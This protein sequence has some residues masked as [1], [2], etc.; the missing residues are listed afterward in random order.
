MKNYLL[1]FLSLISLTVFSQSL[2][3]E[4]HE[5]YFSP[6]GELCNADLDITNLSTQD[7]SVHVT[8]SVI[9]DVSNYFCWGITCYP[10]NSDA[11]FTSSNPLLIPAGETLTG[12][13]SFKGTVNNLP[14]ESSLSINYCF[15][16][17]GSPDDEV[18][19]DL[20][21]TNKDM[22]VSSSDIS[23]IPEIFPN[24]AFNQLK[25]KVKDG[26]ESEFILFDMLGNKVLHKK[27]QIS[28]VINISSLESGIYFYS[29]NVQGEDSEVQ[30]LVVSH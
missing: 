16:I 14:E 4:P 28:S 13:N 12:A 8:R 2:S 21:Y 3:I 20:I 7:V 24:P 9:T 26:V 11:I 19:T 30:K 18:C 27:M 23:F 25:I 29:F 15:W 6:F 17:E 10:P 5:Y 1:T 22:Y